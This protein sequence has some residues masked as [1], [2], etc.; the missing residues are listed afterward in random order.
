MDLTEVLANGMLPT[1]ASTYKQAIRSIH[2][3]NFKVSEP[4]EKPANI[5]G[6]QRVFD[7][8]NGR[9]VVLTQRGRSFLPPFRKGSQLTDTAI[10]K[11]YREADALN[12]R[13]RRPKPDAGGV[14]G[15][16]IDY[17]RDVI[18]PEWSN[19]HDRNDLTYKGV[20]RLG[21]QDPAALFPVE[22][23]T[24]VFSA[25]DPAEEYSLSPHHL[26][27]TVT[28]EELTDYEIK[29]FLQHLADLGEQ[30][31]ILSIPA[32]QALGKIPVPSPNVKPQAVVSQR[33][34]ASADVGALI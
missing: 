18:N 26:Q 8:T 19:Y 10:Q 4:R 21:N 22:F 17:I 1:R 11:V 27:Y 20:I 33:A 15:F 30:D 7:A 13:R 14:V 6:M 24:T 2:G 29:G 16:P 12:K 25:E 32:S 28:G 3:D 34:G 5:D 23:E 31:E 9:F